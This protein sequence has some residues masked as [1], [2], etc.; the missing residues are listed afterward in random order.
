M[1]TEWLLAGNPGHIPDVSGEVG[2]LGPSSDLENKQYK[3]IF[4]LSPI[5]IFFLNIYI[6]LKHS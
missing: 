6:L 2:P 3:A 4:F 1:P 5:L